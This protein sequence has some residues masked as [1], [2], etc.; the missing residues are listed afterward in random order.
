MAVTDVLSAIDALLYL[1]V[2]A[3]Q[4]FRGHHYVIAAGHVLQCPAHEL[5]R[6]AQLIGNRR[7]EEVLA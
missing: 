6:R 3:R 5:L 2:R 1:L 4:E 7:V